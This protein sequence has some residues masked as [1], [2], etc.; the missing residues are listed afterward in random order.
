MACLRPCQYADK[1]LGGTVKTLLAIIAAFGIL[2]GVTVIITMAVV[3]IVIDLDEP[4]YEDDYDE[5]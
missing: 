5:F 3:D 4:E 2:V 1:G